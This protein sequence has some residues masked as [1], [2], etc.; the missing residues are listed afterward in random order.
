MTNKPI[1]VDDESLRK[2]ASYKHPKWCFEELVKLREL[3]T[4]LTVTNWELKLAFPNKTMMQIGEKAQSLQ[5]K[6]NG[7]QP[8][9]RCYHCKTKFLAS[10]KLIHCTTCGKRIRN[11]TRKNTLRR[12]RTANLPESTART[13]QE[14]EAGEA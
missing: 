2:S 7:T 1:G 14:I 11:K 5:L 9:V 8:L 6:R 13:P 10:D 4:D 12:Q 3:Y